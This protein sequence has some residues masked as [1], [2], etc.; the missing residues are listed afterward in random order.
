[1]R[2]HRIR[3]QPLTT[4]SFGIRPKQILESR[5]TTKD[6]APQPANRPLYTGATETDAERPAEML[7]RDRI[8]WQALVAI[9][10]ARPAG[11]LHDP[12]S[13]KWEAR[14]VYAHL[15]R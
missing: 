12:E 8:E 10:D 4:A 13:P 5:G 9:L 3:K 14:D 7:R 1:M 6:A 2:R 15:A 11:A